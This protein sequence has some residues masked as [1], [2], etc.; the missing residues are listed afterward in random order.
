MPSAYTGIGGL[1]GTNAGEA[2]P[3]ENPLNNT[4]ALDVDL[5]LPDPVKFPTSGNQYPV[6]VMMHGCC[7]GNKTSWEGPTIDPGGAENWHYNNAWF[8]SRGYIVVTYTARGFVDGS[9]HGS[10]GQTQLDSAKYEI[11]DYQHLVGQLADAGDLDPG[12]GT[13]RVDPQR[14]VPTGG[15]Y[16]GGFTWL[17]LTD[18]T[19]NSPGASTPMKVVAAAT[20]YGW[21]N[22]VESLV[23]RGDDRRDSLPETDPATVKSRLA[24]T[25]GFPKR[26]INAALYASGKTGVPP[27]SSHTTFAPD[28]DEA[29]ACLTAPP[30]PPRPTPC[31]P[32]RSPPLCPRFID[33]RSAY[34]QQGFFDGLADNSIADVPVF[35]AGTFTDK[36]FPAAE[37]RRMVE[38]LKSTNASYPVQEYYGDYNHF[39]QTKRKEFADVCG[40][41]VCGYED[42]PGGDLNADPPSRSLEPGVTKRLNDFIDHYAAPPAN[43]SEGTPAFDVTGALQVCPGNA[44]FLGRDPDEPGLRFTAANFAALAPNSLQ[45]NAAGTQLT[46]NPVP[47]ANAHGKTA[48]PVGNLATNDGACPVEQSPGGVATAG[49]GVATYDSQALSRN[50]T[51]LGQAR[52]TVAHTGTGPARQLN[53][54]LYDLAPDGE[55][56]MVDRG[57]KRITSAIGPTTL[58]LHGAG[59]R[60]ASGHKLRLEVTQDD[61]TYIKAS[62]LPSSLTLSGVTMKVPVRESSGTVGGGPAPRP[63]SGG[64]SAGSGSGSGQARA[65]AR[66][67]AS[68]ALP[69][70]ASFLRATRRHDLSRHRRLRVRIGLRRRS[71][72]A[73]V[74]RRRGPRR[75]ARTSLRKNAGRRLV[76]LRVSRSARPGRHRLKV[77]I[78]CAG[79]RPQT[80]YRRV[81]FVR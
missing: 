52:V 51:M 54:R 46:S 13:V 22:L 61:E 32:T 53:A 10:T 48:D 2:V 30:T 9:N 38:R 77:R 70:C 55:Q 69:P 41:D 23:P 59:W 29:Q 5:S 44:S 7:S 14:I 43:A 57:V 66:A 67:R 73:A 28:I 1:P 39:V 50:F 6:V 72:I 76:T 8:A 79:S 75:W 35:S 17:A 3:G 27:G 34:Y 18:P 26:S 42:Y 36:L 80:V 4:V 49:P 16:G 21:T 12:S 71:R 25:P 63:P 47:G 20:K 62:S 74:V 24:A 45:V 65:R 33:E 60:F 15:S 81:R 31:A 58:D 37:H 11:N 68:G 78:S 56:V 64:S 19:W 40:D